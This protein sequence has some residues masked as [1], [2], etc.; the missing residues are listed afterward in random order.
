MLLRVPFGPF[1][2]K[3]RK[4]NSYRLRLAEL[5]KELFHRLR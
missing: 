1:P 5:T 2:T 3:Y 4:K